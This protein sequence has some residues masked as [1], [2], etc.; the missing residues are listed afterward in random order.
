MA[1]LKTSVQLVDPPGLPLQEPDPQTRSGRTAPVAEADPD[2]RASDRS[3]HQ[4]HRRN[5][6]VLPARAVSAASAR[7]NSS[8]LNGNTS[9][10]EERHVFVPGPASKTWEHRYVEISDNL[11]EWLEAC[12]KDR[13]GKICPGDFGQKHQGQ[14]QGGGNRGV[15]AGRDAPHVRQQPSRPL[16][17]PRRS[18]PSDGA[19]VQPANALALLPQGTDEIRGS[20][21]LVDPSVEPTEHRGVCE[22]WLVGLRAGASTES[23]QVGSL[24]WLPSAIKLRTA[25]RARLCSTGTSR[26]SRPYDYLNYG[27]Y[28]A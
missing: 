11:L 20:E 9:N 2:K 15:E 6:A 13:T 23:E 27:S 14:L 16:R 28:T 21:F 1:V 10:I 19:S 12:C 18:P 26:V 17:K 25:T 22:S 24:D 3:T 7:R 5:P 8:A 4:V